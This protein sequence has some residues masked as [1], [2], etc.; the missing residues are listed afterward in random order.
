ML[1]SLRV[2]KDLPVPIH[3]ARDEPRGQPLAIRLSSLYRPQERL[4][5]GDLGL[6]G[7]RDMYS[8]TAIRS[9]GVRA[10][11]TVFIKGLCPMGPA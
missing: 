5:L 2:A 10:N 6:E 11:A 9:A 4:L 3:S 8:A 7:W 1:T